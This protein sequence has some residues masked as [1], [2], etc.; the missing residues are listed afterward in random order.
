[1]CICIP[2]L[3]TRQE[4]RV[5]PAQCYLSC[6]VRLA[7]PYF[8]TFFHKRHNFRGKKLL[9]IKCVLIFSATFVRNISFSKSNADIIVN[10]LA[11]SRKVPLMLVRFQWNL[12]FLNRFSKKKSSNTKF[13]ENTSNGNRVVTFE[14]TDRQ[15]DIIIIIYLSW[16]WTTC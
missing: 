7:A 15:I 8:S 11:C 16:S 5:F 9:N 13:H 10:V 4:N 3:A 1:M 12:N 14:R 2:A 6:V